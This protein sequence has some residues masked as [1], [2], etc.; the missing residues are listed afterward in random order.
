MGHCRKQL[1]ARK[2][3]LFGVGAGMV[4]LAVDGVAG[5][6]VFGLLICH[7]PAKGAGYSSFNQHYDKRQTGRADL[8]VS[9]PGGA[10]GPYHPMLQCCFDLL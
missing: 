3:I 7:L 6:I 10:A 4:S 8:L 1:V 2:K 5:L 9:Q